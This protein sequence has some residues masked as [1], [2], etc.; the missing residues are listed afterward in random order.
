MAVITQESR[1]VSQVETPMSN[2][3]RQR[4]GGAE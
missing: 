1:L 4:T 3:A 2:C